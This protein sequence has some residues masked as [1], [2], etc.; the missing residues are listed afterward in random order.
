MITVRSVFNPWEAPYAKRFLIESQW[1][2]DPDRP[3][4]H[5]EG[6][7]KDVA[8]SEEL[9]TWF[10]NDRSRWREFRKQYF[11]ELDAH[12]EAWRHLL[13]E[14]RYGVV[15]LLYCSGDVR[16]NNALALKEYLET[17]LPASARGRHPMSRGDDREGVMK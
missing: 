7:L 1:P 4:L 17:K 13:E 2:R 10:G 14:A 11:A 12:P 6:W 9:R 15:E 8:P 5:F 16:H 3:A